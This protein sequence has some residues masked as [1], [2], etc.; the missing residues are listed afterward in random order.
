LS[1]SPKFLKRLGAALA[2]L[3][4]VLWLK[5]LTWPAIIV[6]I[7]VGILDLYLIRQKYGTITVWIRGLCEKKVDNVIIIAAFVVVWIFLGPKAYLAY[8]VGYLVCHFFE[9]QE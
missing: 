5:S 9:V 6:F 3:G 4:A 8:M 1:K 2:V 7:I